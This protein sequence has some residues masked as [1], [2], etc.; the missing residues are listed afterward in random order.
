M[1]WGGVPQGRRGRWSEA[2]AE[3]AAARRP[4]DPMLRIGPLP[5][6]MG[7]ETRRRYSVPGAA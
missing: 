3:I 6:D 5:H 4:F 2:E 7:K 1:S